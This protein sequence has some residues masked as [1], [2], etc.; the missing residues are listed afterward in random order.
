[1]FL[2]KIISFTVYFCF[3]AICFSSQSKE[4]IRCWETEF[5]GRIDWN[6]VNA[7]LGDDD[8]DKK[9]IHCAVCYDRTDILRRLI[10]AGAD[11]NVK[12]A[13][14][15]TP[16]HCARTKEQV[17]LLLGAGAKTNLKNNNRWTPI[18]NLAYGGNIELVEALLDAGIR[19]EPVWLENRGISSAMYEM[20]EDYRK[21]DRC[22]IKQNGSLM[23]QVVWHACVQYYKGNE[24]LLWL[25]LLP[26]Q[27]TPP[28]ITEKVATYFKDEILHNEIIPAFY[29]HQSGGYL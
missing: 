16:L 29:R 12:N 26:H 23:E 3:S 19:P 15:D 21:A 20:F 28:L 7:S 11:V 14:R 9:A 6:N 18:W 8:D 25:L 10:D 1:M 4:P 24:D 27:G 5:E 17:E 13:H 22:F 2:I